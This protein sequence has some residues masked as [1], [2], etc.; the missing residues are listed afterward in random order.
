M[1]AN[2]RFEL[3][4]RAWHPPSGLKILN[5]CC[6]IFGWSYRGGAAAHQLIS[7]IMLPSY[8]GGWFFCF[9]M[10]FANEL[11]IFFDNDLLKFCLR[12]DQRSLILLNFKSHSHPVIIGTKEGGF[13]EAAAIG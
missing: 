6:A 11:I 5:Y 10:S 8:A 3:L 13:Y 4:P 1:L 12:L 2:K 9:F 7:E